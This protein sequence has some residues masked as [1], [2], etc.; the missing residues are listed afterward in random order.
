MIITTLEKTNRQTYASKANANTPFKG[1]VT[2]SIYIQS[3]YI[4][5]EAEMIEIKMVMPITIIE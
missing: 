5:N 4:L 2:S 3:A 1:T